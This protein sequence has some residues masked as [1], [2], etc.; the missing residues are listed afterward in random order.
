MEFN[1]P[2]GLVASP[3][4]MNRLL[5]NNQTYKY[6]IEAANGTRIQLFYSYLNLGTGPIC[7]R[8]RLT[9]YEPR[10]INNTGSEI[11][12]LRNTTSYLSTGSSVLLVFKQREFLGDLGFKIYYAVSNQGKCII[13]LS[14]TCIN[15]FWISSHIPK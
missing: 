7:D 13:A 12:C 9:I 2:E 11:H 14:L 3:N 4:F 1:W 5:P 15:S 10:I 8:L 6:Q